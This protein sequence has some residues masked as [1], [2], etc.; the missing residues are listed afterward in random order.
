MKVKFNKH[1][2]L[3]FLLVFFTYSFAATNSSCP[4]LDKNGNRRIDPAALALIEKCIKAQPATK[5]LYFDNKT[6]QYQPARQ[7]LHQ[8]IINEIFTKPCLKNNIQPIAIL[9][10][11]LYGA[12]KSTFLNKNVADIDSYAHVD[13]DAIRAELPEYQGWNAANTQDEVN[14]IIKL[15]LAHIGKPCDMNII[16]DSNMAVAERYIK[17]IHQLKNAHYQIYIIY[18]KLPS[19]VAV[20]RATQRYQTEGRYVSKKFINIANRRVQPTFNFIKQL[21]DGY[22]IVDGLTGKILVQQ[23]EFTKILQKN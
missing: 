7:E 1:F 11:G 18:I 20:Q 19:T 15:V 5:T 10:A 13:D 12:G 21:A 3:V 9:T 17:L 22:L 6:L 14:D 4:P 2:I 16:Y 23:G 8:K